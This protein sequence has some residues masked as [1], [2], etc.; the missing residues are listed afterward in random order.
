M[1]NYSL[2]QSKKDKLRERQEGDF[3][4]YQHSNVHFQQ[5]QQKHKTY[6]EMKKYGPFKQSK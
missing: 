1:D 6:K 3:Q 5:Q 4:S 2:Q